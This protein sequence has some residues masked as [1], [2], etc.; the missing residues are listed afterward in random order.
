M[1]D[2]GSTVRTPLVIGNWKMNP[3]SMDAALELAGGVRAGAEG[4]TD[5]IAVVCP[6]AIWLRAVADSLE[7]GPVKI[8]AQT[9]HAEEGGAFTGEISPLMLTGLAEYVIIGHSER[10]QYACETDQTVAAKVASAVRHGLRPILALGERADE[11]AA[12]ATEAVID[13]QL[14]I[15]LSRVDRLGGSRLVIAYEPVWAIG[16]GEP[17]FPADAQAVASEIRGTLRELDPD[18]ADEIAILYGGSVTPENAA[19]F[20]EQ[21]EIDG[22]LV[23]GSCLDAG[24][25]GAI[26]QLAARSAH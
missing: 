23:G 3:A 24:G 1:P 10:R 9:M 12:G 7:G 16:S 18:A 6:P 19:A 22:A 20:F 5:A 13:R 26:L 2:S 25:F 11:R 15:G 17:A 8:G 14:R 21:P 4:L